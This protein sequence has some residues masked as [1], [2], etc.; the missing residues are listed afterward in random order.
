LASPAALLAQA[1]LGNQGTVTL[2]VLA[3]QVVEQL[4]TLGNQAQ[5][6]TTGVVILGVLL[7]VR[8][9]DR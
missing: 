8:L 7:E 2:D 5:Q 3:L 9:S 4:A 6:T 1:E